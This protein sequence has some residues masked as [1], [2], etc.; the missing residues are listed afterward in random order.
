MKR[1]LALLVVAACLLGAES[2]PSGVLEAR[3]VSV[4]IERSPEDVYRFASD[5]RNLPRWASGLGGEIRSVDGRWIADGPLGEVEVRFVE[6]NDLGVLDHD[7][8]P[9]SG[10]TVR[11]PMRVL[12]NGDG[13]EVTFTLFRR[14]G[15]S[16]EKLDED[17]RWVEKDLRKLK[18]VLEGDRGK[19]E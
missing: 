12:A 10:P 17:A 13:S 2:A 8:V 16:A 6:R 9:E 5:P 7:V 3:H 11:N 15:V 4:S 19:H 14:P 18:S 1:I